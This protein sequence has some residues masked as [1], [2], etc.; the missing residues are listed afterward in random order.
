M[1][2]WVTCSIPYLHKTLINGGQFVSIN[3]DGELDY[4]VEKRLQVRGSFD[5]SIQIR[6]LQSSG[7]CSHIRFDGNPAKFLQGHNVF[8]SSDLSGLVIAC[9]EKVLPLVLPSDEIQ[10]L[11]YL[12][13][14]VHCSRLTRIDLTCMYDLSNSNNVRTWLR[15][16]GES[17]N[18]RF[19][20]RGQ[21]SGDTLYWGKHSRRWSL[22]VYAKGD[23]LRAHKPK[24]GIPDH[25]QHLKSVTDYADKSLRVELVLRAMELDRMG[26]DS[27]QCWDETLQYDVYSSYL[28]R[29]E[30]S[31][32]MK[33]TTA[34]SDLEN[35]PPRLRGCVLLWLEGHDLRSM[36]SRAQ[37]YRYRKDIMAAIGLDIS[38][39][40]PKQRP[41]TSNVVPL[42][43]VLEAKPMGIPEWAYGTPLYFEPPAYPRLVLIKS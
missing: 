22:K 14:T 32:N 16:A 34:V 8:G 24:K 31:D 21:F 4:C 25:P 23:E 28:S 13:M 38:L 9:F 30:F 41:D 26:L 36:Y 20:G 29:L 6:S 2:D 1:I 15:A 43:R 18:L 10:S 33:V 12:I 7:Y 17:V 42:M 35:L 3:P 37:W 39:S 11:D 40:P 19:K 27:I 5:S